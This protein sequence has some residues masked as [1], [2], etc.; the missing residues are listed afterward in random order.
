MLAALSHAMLH[1]ATFILLYETANVVYGSFILQNDTLLMVY[2]T[3]LMINGSYI[4][5]PGHFS[6]R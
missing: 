5:I 2:D 4:I 6:S 3:L 1:V